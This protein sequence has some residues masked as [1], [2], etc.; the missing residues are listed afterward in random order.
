MKDSNII[1]NIKLIHDGK[2]VATSVDHSRFIQIYILNV[3]SLVN[4]VSIFQ[5]EIFT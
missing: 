3:I 2:P 1:I 4:N 5:I